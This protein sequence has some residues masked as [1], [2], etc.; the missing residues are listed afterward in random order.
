MPNLQGRPGV[1]TEELNVRLADL[2]ISGSFQDSFLISG[3]SAVWQTGYTFLIS[4]ADY[5]IRGVRYTSVQT[6][7]VLSAAHATLDRI[8]VLVVDTSGVAAA[9]EGT[10]AAQPSEPDIDPITQLKIAIVLVSA[11]T[12]QPTATSTLDLYL[13]NAGSTAE[14][15][16]AASAGSWSLSGA[17]LPR[18]GSVCVIVTSAANNSNI[19]GT[20][21]SGTI[22]INDYD[23]LAVYI[24][25]TSTWANN[26]VLRVQ[27]QD[28]NSVIKGNTLTIAS[29]YFGFNSSNTT[30]YQLIAIPT[31][32]FAIADGT[33]VSKLK[34]FDSGGAISFR[35]DDISLTGGTTTQTIVGITQEQ[36]D[37]RYILRSEVKHHVLTPQAWAVA[38]GTDFWLVPSANGMLTSG[39]GHELSDYGWTTTALALQ[40]GSGGDF[41]SSA[42]PGALGAILFGASGDLLLSPAVFGDYAHFYMASQLLGAAPT[43]LILEAIAAFTTNS[44][45]ETTS[46]FGFIE[47]GGSP[48]VANDH[49]AFIFTDGTNFTL[50]SGAASD[51]GAVDD[52]NV[53]RFKI[54]ITSANVEWFIDGTSQ[55]TIALEADEFPVA[56]GAHVLTTNRLS[57]GIVHISYE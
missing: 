29:G 28:S 20:I 38:A 2:Q 51:A 54:V 42:D 12:T 18:T 17:T 11:N 22:D 43:K 48:D 41:F 36:A 16:W 21:G 30:D 4:A 50:R 13:E 5:F 1:T 23:F 9:V 56:F 26:R 6:E 57:L 15:D 49:L 10:A 19:V 31:S 47:D 32:Q 44:A 35:L 40:N 8:D 7:V 34:F 46:G 25:S 39:N 14:W 37:A 45:N 53:H 3:G 33:A 55:G 27:W 52:G 24:R